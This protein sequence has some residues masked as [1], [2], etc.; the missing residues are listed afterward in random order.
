MKFK[1][2]LAAALVAVL[3]LTA[4]G[5]GSDSGSTPA[6]KGEDVATLTIT[7][8]TVGTGPAAVSGN[9]LSVQYTLWLYSS[10]AVGN[11]GK[12]IESNVGSAPFTF[13]LGAG[14]V[15][16]GWDQGL[17]GVMAGG[18]RTLIIPS[19]LG[20]GP[21]GQGAIPGGSALVFDVT[22]ATIN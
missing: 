8:P 2:L 3:G 18:K 1:L 21:N 14:Q 16:P 5:G 15:I 4:C 7:N 12:Q 22:V 9:N 6:V 13:K 17:V 19:S 11:K 20:Y 10:T